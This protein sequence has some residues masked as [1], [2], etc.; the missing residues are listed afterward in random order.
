MLMSGVT[1]TR[2]SN[3]KSEKKLRLRLMTVSSACRTRTNII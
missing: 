1:N 2:M 3:Q